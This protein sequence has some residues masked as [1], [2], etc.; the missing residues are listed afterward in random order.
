MQPRISTEIPTGVLL[1]LLS[2]SAAEDAWRVFLK[3]Y[4]GR[5]RAWACRHVSFADAEQIASDVLDKL[6]CGT[7]LV[8]FDHKRGS[9]RAWLRVVVRRTIIDFRR[10]LGKTPGSIGRGMGEG[11]PLD[12]L[13]DPA[14]LDGLTGDLDVRLVRDLR[15]AEV[16]VNRVR[17]RVK[18]HTWKAY[19]RTAVLGRD[20]V[21]V[22]DAL[23]LSIRAVYMARLRVGQMLAEEGRALLGEHS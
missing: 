18:P 3:R 17:D 23:G 20:A 14:S 11:N 21:E 15:A 13:V 8:S 22:A 5:I 19:Y 7:A 12:A 9:F 4:W 2:G 6:V 16:V 1:S 10:K